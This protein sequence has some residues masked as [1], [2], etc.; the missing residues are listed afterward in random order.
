MLSAQAQTPTTVQPTLVVQTG[1]VKSIAVVAVSPDNKVIASGSEDQN[2][3]R[4]H[5]KL[6]RWLQH[7]LLYTQ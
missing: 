5:A 1:H 6:Q 3:R 7:A 2:G 4:G